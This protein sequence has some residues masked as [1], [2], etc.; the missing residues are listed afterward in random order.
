MLFDNFIK[1]YIKSYIDWSDKEYDITE[2]DIKDIIVYIKCDDRLW[3]VLDNLISYQL[4]DYVKE[5]D[6]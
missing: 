1:Q 4:D 3:K 6:E 2:E 5:C